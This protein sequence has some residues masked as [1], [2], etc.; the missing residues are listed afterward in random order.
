MLRFSDLNYGSA[1]STAGPACVS[2]SSSHHDETLLD[3]YVLD[4]IYPPGGGA[5]EDDDADDD[6]DGERGLVPVVV[7]MHGGAWLIGDKDQHNSRAVCFQIA[8]HG[9]VAVSVSYSLTS[10]SNRSLT[11]VF[12]FVTAVLG[13]IAL[14]STFDE[15]ALLMATWVIL[16]F[17]ILAVVV[18]RDA[19]EC[20]HPCHVRDCAAALR[21]V[22]DHAAEYGG[23]PDTVFVVGHSAGAHLTA[24][25]ATNPLYLGEVGMSPRDLAGAVCISGVYN[26]AELRSGGSL[27]QNVLS[28]CFG[29]YRPDHVQAFPIHHVRPDLCPPFLL[30]NAQRDYSLKR[31]ARE[32]LSTCRLHG[33]Y[34][35]ARTYADT[36][37]YSVIL[38]WDRRNWRVLRDLLFFLE[39]ATRARRRRGHHHHRAR[40]LCVYDE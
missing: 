35:D 12:L 7:Y 17:V 19:D 34:C 15:K 8:E 37:H 39:T 30:Q 31:H 18:Q 36:N 29:A 16:S 23:D 1:C 27:A 20:Q 24:L 6:D 38:E 21:W 40:G 10:L 32:F 11:N 3:L 14:V 2:S 26:D 13:V 25:L 4:R 5:R 28:E 22:R 9:Y 33:V